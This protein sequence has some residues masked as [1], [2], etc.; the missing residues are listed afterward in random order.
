MKI[1]KCK[2]CGK[3]TGTGDLT[4]ECIDCLDWKM[5]ELRK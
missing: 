2:E 4:D 3:L 1:G 5:Q